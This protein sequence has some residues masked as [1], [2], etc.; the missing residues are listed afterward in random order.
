MDTEDIVC[1]LAKIHFTS[2]DYEYELFKN[3]NN[4]YFGK[5]RNGNVVY[6][7]KS[8]SQKSV[9]SARSTKK[10]VLMTDVSCNFIIDNVS[11]TMTSNII[12]C[13]SNDESEVKSFLRL[14]LAYSC[15]DVSTETLITFFSSM[16]SLFKES[17]VGDRSELMGFFAEL[18]TIYYLKERGI[19]ISLC[20]QKKD[21]MKF[22]FTISSTKRMDVKSSLTG[23]RKHH[24]NHEQLFYEE[25]DIIIVSILLRLADVGISIFDIVEYCRKIY[26]TDIIHLSIIEK[27]IHNYTE[28]DLKN[29]IFDVPYLENNIRFVSAKDV[30]RFN[31][32]SPTGVYNAEYDSDLSQSK[33]FPIEEL[34]IW[35]DSIEFD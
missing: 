14:C 6:V 26:S 9:P 5:D 30:P 27:K 22:D 16:V 33:Q 28:S 12:V 31:E 32:I 4:N 15:G 23:E 13:K 11:K 1:Q 20:W 8:T 3:D 17:T 10:L 19:D 25:Y 21:M 18:Y 29:I 7:I 24:F 35:V 2:S 34:K